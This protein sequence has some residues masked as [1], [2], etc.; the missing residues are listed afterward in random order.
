M[1]QSF[2]RGSRFGGSGSRA[3]HAFRADRVPV[4]RRSVRKLGNSVRGPVGRAPWRDRRIARSDR[5]EE[6]T[7]ELQSLMRSSYAVF[8][9]KKKR[10]KCNTTHELTYRNELI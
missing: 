2:L 6:H 7:S 1:D 4:P 9:L 3:L 10:Q 5:S 8:C